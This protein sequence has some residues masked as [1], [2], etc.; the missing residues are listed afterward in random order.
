MNNG[1]LLA[2]TIV[3][4]AQMGFTML[5]LDVR[6]HHPERYRGPIRAWGEF[7][8]RRIYSFAGSASMVATA[9]VLAMIG[10]TR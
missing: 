7:A 10:F 1:F 2:M 5:A 9:A 8:R 3:A 4:C 6:D